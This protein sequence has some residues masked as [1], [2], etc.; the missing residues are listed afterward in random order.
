MLKRGEEKKLKKFERKF[1]W[2]IYDSKRIVEGGV[3][4]RLMNSEVLERLQGKDIMKA[5]T[6]QRLRWHGHIKSMGEEKVVKKV[7]EWKPDFRRARGRP[8]NR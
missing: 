8:K 3:P 1:V 7:T 4:Q 2:K 5:T 6:T